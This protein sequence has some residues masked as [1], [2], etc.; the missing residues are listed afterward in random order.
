M[1]AGRL[2][3]FSLLVHEGEPGHA[4]ARYPP[5]CECVCVNANV[6]LCDFLHITSAGRDSS[7][8]APVVAS[9]VYLTFTR[10]TG[11]QITQTNLTSIPTHQHDR[12]DRIQRTP[13]LNRV[14]GDFSFPLL[15][16]SHHL[17]RSEVASAPFR[18]WCSDV[19]HACSAGPLPGHLGEPSFTPQGLGV[20]HL[21]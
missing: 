17:V 14:D 10:D 20:E 8:V 1:G 3:D 4:P 11:T 9:V 19:M 2:V 7:A 15:G 18:I 13:C 12:D 6:S 5:W 21:T 16:C